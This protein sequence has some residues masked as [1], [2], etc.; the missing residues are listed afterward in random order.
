[1]GVGR[2]QETPASLN[3]IQEWLAIDGW[4]ELIS[5]LGEQMVI[6]LGFLSH[7]EFDESELRSELDI[8]KTTPVS[9]Q[10]RIAWGRACIDRVLNEDDGYLLPSIH[11]FE[12][13]GSDGSTVIIGCLFEIHGQLG[14]VTNWR[15]LWRSR[16]AFLQSLGNEYEYWVTPLMGDMP[17]EVILQLWKRSKKRTMGLK[18]ENKG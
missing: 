3:D 2:S 16:D 7:F 5:D 6:N 18:P 14:P 12:L 11:T 8:P 17:D 9:D 1:M 10:D 13:K 15:G 4:D